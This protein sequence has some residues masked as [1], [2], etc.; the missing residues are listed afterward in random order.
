VTTSLE[1]GEAVVAVSDS[2]EGIPEAI[3]PRIFDLF[4]TT[5]DVGTGVGAGLALAYATITKEHG[6]KLTFTTG[7]EGTTFFVRLPLAVSAAPS[8]SASA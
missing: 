3:R 1:D 2:G 7:A 4:F 5:K 6:G 8:A